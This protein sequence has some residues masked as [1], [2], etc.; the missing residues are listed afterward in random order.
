[1]HISVD[2]QSRMI[3]VWMVPLRVLLKTILSSFFFYFT[4]ESLH[5]KMDRTCVWKEKSDYL[6]PYKRDIYYS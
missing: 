6:I 1:M 2:T 5:F 3:V 4:L